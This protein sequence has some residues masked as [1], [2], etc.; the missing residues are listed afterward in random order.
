[1]QVVICKALPYIIIVSVSVAGAVMIGFSPSS[2]KDGGISV[3]ALY[4]IGGSCLW[5]F[6][7]T[8][9]NLAV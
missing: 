1:M 2:D 9:Q 6:I 8:V 4:A 5:V 7:H 3:G